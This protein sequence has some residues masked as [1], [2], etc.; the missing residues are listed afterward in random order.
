M[1]AA[2]VANA[3]TVVWNGPMGV[4]E[5]PPFDAGTR[6]VAESIANSGS[7]SIIGGGD[8]AA[9]IQQLGFADRVTHV[10]TGGGASL[11]MLEGEK[12]AAVELLDEA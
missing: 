2:E 5:M 3:G 6:A 12:F 4:F 11:A 9:A 7:T 10:S 8:S 1:Y